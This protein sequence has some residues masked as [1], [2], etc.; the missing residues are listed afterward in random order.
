MGLVNFA[1]IFETI[2]LP[3]KGESF[4]FW[5]VPIPKFGNH[6]LA[7]DRVGNPTLLL[8]AQGDT[9]G[10]S[11]PSI[12]LQNLIVEFDVRCR[13]KGGNESFEE[14]FCVLRFIGQN[15]LLQNYFFKL[16]RTL[17]E[18]LG[19]TPNLYEVRN[20]IHQ[21][22]ELL[23]L[24]TEIPQNT[25]QGLWGEL[26][27]ISRHSKL[28][29]CWHADPQEKFDFSNG[30]ERIEVKSC[31]G[32]LR[33]HSFSIEQLNPP[34]DVKAFVA[35]IFVL[36]NAG[37][38]S[39]DDLEGEIIAKARGNTALISKLRLLISQTLGNS[40]DGTSLKFDYQ[41]AAE[42]LRFFYIEDIPRIISSQVPPMVSHVK[43]QSNLSETNAIQNVDVLKDF[44]S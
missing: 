14:S 9:I 5:A 24:A 35:S 40:F 43:F 21:L 32:G 11:T 31:S 30:R 42:S 1:E 26:F 38:L 3:A 19:N 29:E 2:S 4:E 20:E 37:G 12:M 18:N 28:L 10:A 17:L 41:L 27:L 34:H 23:R 36:T 13:V 15:I 25:I 7:K 33:I 22:V 44:F 39:I 16:S 8:L 6:R